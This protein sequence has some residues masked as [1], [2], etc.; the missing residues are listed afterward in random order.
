MTYTYHNLKI[1]PTVKF[2]SGA[3]MLYL[4][5]EKERLI[6]TLSDSEPIVLL[7]SQTLGEKNQDLVGVIEEDG[8]TLFNNYKGVAQ[9]ATELLIDAGT[10]LL[11][12]KITD[13]DEL[14]FPRSLLQEN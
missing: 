4:T 9:K 3:R 8:I 10:F 13:Y 14:D 1:E 2:V 12:S 6:L 5:F 11:T 7:S